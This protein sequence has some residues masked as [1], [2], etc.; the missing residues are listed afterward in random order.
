MLLSRLYS[1]LPAL[2]PSLGGG[3]AKKACAYAL[4][5]KS[6][7]IARRTSL[8]TR[9]QGCLLFVEALRRRMT[10]GTRPSW[11]VKCS[12]SAFGVTAPARGPGKPAAHRPNARDFVMEATENRDSSSITFWVA[13]SPCPIGTVPGFKPP[14][15]E[16]NIAASYHTLRPPAV[17]PSIRLAWGEGIKD[18][19]RPSEY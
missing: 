12:Q 3:H 7:V 9:L 8:V 1:P 15:A 11:E 17:R 13:L 18:L 5:Q 6:D 10:R 19:S 2:P 4:S 16:E 14:L